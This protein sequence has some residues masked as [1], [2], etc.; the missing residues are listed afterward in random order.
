MIPQQTLN[1]HIQHVCF[2]LNTVLAMFLGSTYLKTVGEIILY[3]KKHL[4]DSACVNF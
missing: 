1:N 2:L 3:T 4:H